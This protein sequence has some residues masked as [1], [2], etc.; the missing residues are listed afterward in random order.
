MDRDINE[1]TDTDL[2]LKQTQETKRFT[3][4]FVQTGT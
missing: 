3:L 2:R 4:L 1:H